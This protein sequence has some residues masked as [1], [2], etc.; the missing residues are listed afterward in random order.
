MQPISR[1]QM[2]LNKTDAKSIVERYTERYNKFGYSPKALGWK[3]GRQDVRFDALTS[4][5]DFNHKHVLDIGCGFGDLNKVLSIKA[6]KYKYTGVDLVEALLSE[7]KRQFKGKHIRFLNENILEFEPGYLFDY[8]ISSGVFNHR[9][10][11]R[12]NYQFIEQVI[13]KALNICKDGLAFDFLSD[14]VDYKLKHT[15]HSSPERILS[16][17]YKYSRNIVLRN[18]YMPF[19]FTVFI[20]KDDSYKKEDAIFNRFKY[21]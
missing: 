18:D 20:F 13:Q 4:Q 11:E 17:A 6:S 15:F 10:S 9:L 5:Y 8:A 7:A 2:I 16:I 14:K 21:L 3:K 1:P 19:E 12:R